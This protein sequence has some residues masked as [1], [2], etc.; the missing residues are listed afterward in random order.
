[1]KPR[2]TLALAS[3]L[4][5]FIAAPL[6]AQAQFNYVVTNGTITITGYTGP[7]GA[8]SIPAVINGLPVTA[9]AQDAFFLQ[10]QVTSVTI[11]NSV[12]N[13][14][15]AGGFVA[16]A[17]LTNITVDS[18]NP[19]FS[20]LDGVLF[21]KNQATLLSF[22]WGRGGNYKIPEGVIHIAYYAFEFRP[23]LSGVTIPDT[24]PDIGDAAF[25]S[26]VGLTNVT[27]GNGVTN[28]DV[29]AFEDCVALAS[30]TIGKSV[31]IIAGG[32]FYGCTNLASI[33]IPNSVVDLQGYEGAFIEFGAFAAC[34]GLTNVILGESVTNIGM[35]A[36]EGC[37]S[38]R[39]I[40]VPASVTSIGIDAFAYCEGLTSVF[41]M[42]NAPTAEPSA[43]SDFP[44]S[45]PETAYY[46]LGTAGWSNTFAHLPTALWLPQPVNGDG[47]FGVRSN[48]FGF[49]INWARGK[50]VVV[51]A[52]MNLANPAWL[53][54][55]TNTL[56]T[57]TSY[58]SDPQPANLPSRFYRLRSP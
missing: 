2:Y 51:D 22:P 42:G 6:S 14:G 5:A 29:V 4:A 27:I 35:A 21:D 47:S 55:S 48:Q 28:I 1:M 44:L 34:S 26:C 20:S 49:N 43:F 40:T 32:A 58:F 12:T 36:F 24:V 15:D 25:S 39:N 41:F 56:V 3:G 54:V 9:L 18:L 10:D 33:V 17:S 13:V 38:L 37:T 50:T 53:P 19:V 23:N 16:C 11:P 45:S 31:R 8:V 57:G 46:L 30:V 52:C 7:G